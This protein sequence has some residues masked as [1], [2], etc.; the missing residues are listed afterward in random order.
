M[1]SLDV[2]VKRWEAKGI[3]AFPPYSEAVIRATS[4]EAGIEPSKDL[5]DLY[6][7]IGGMEIPDNQLWCLWPLAVVDKRKSEANEFG[8]L[9]SDYLLDAWVYRVKPNDMDTSAVYVD[10]FD[11]KPPPLVAETLEQ[12][13]DKYVTNAERLLNEPR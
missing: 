5:V 10:Y 9:F 8:V 1:K 11:G 7:T 4:L 6:H 13:F 3:E 12:F 2:L